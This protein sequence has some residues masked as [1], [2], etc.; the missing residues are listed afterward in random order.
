MDKLKMHSPDLTTT[1]IA[2]IREM[3]PSCVTEARGGLREPDT[4]VGRPTR[5]FLP[6]CCPSV[7]VP[8]SD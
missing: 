5:A 4:C 8:F 2:R 3:F 6:C 7:T 1:N